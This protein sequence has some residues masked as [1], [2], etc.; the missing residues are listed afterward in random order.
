METAYGP[1]VKARERLTAEGRWQDCRAEMLALAE[2]RNEATD[3][4]LHMEAEYLI[5]I[6]HKVG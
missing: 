5:T 1:T 6:A 4:S 3:G 2:R